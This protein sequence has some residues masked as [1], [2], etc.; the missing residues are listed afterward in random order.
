[1]KC[2]IIVQNDRLTLFLWPHLSIA[3]CNLLSTLILISSNTHS[4]VVTA[5]NQMLSEIV[6]LNVTYITLF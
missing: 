5:I 1:M 2:T 6:A 3:A 4:S